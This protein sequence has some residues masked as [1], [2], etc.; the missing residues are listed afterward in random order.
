MAN[1]SGGNV[2]FN[3]NAD[4]LHLKMQAGTQY[5]FNDVLNDTSFAITNTNHIVLSLPS[6]SSKILIF[7][8]KALITSVENKNNLPNKFWLDQNYPNPF[9]PTTTIKYSI[10]GSSSAAVKILIYNILGQKVRTLVDNA[11]M[12]GVYT[13]QWNSKNDSG[14][15]V[16]TGVYF[17]VLK[18]DDFFQIKKMILLK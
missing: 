3:F 18:V 15:M 11:Q 8:D 7:S 17:Y 9:N 13:I 16:A 4:S 6:F 2:N 10:G 14:N 5:Y 1:F 12:P